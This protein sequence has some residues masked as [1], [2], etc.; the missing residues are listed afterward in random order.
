MDVKAVALLSGGLDSSLAVRVVQEQ[1]VEVEGIHFLSVFNGSAPATPTVLR[2]LRVA[3]QLGIRFRP[4]NFTREQLGLVRHPAH[5]YGANMNP[6]IDC[7]MAMLRRA[8][9]IMEDVGAR[10]IV[11]GEV[12]GQ[13]PMSQRRRVLGE[14]NRETGLDGLILRP[15]SAKLLPPSIPEKEG[16]V[17]RE[18]LLDIQGRSRKR[19]LALAAEYGITEHA[20]PAGGCLLT[21]PRFSTRL[22]DLLDAVG[23]G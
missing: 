10:F 20:S 9:K 21:D 17:D 1:G 2:P 18:R 11:T 7:H 15:L 5:G 4:V 16:W 22:R 6:C 3:R 12:V 19:Q 13:R 23:D 8:A 14:I